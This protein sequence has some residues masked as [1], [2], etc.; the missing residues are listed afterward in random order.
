MYQVL[1]L[2]TSRDSEAGSRGASQKTHPVLLLVPLT[3]ASLQ[4]DQRRSIERS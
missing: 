2:C 3:Y 4:G 1:P